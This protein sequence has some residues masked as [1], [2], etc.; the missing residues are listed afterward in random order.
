ML[1][2]TESEI[3]L[4]VKLLRAY[5]ELTMRGILIDGNEQTDNA[6]VKLCSWNGFLAICLEVFKSREPSLFHNFLQPGNRATSSRFHFE[7]IVY[8]YFVEHTSS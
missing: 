2:K 3:G 5:R 1:M 4:L 8:E 6:T 7:S